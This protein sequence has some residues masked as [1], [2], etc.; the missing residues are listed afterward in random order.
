MALMGEM[1]RLS[2]FAA[3]LATQFIAI[4]GAE[5]CR[6]PRRPLIPIEGGYESVVLAT[7]VAH[8]EYEARLR[9]NLPS[10]RIL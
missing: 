4:A 2:L 5:A 1:A 9:R 10:N 8:T 7:V 3:F 6:I